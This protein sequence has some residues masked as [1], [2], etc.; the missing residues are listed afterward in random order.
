MRGLRFGA[1]TS[2]SIDASVAERRGE[3]TADTPAKILFTSGST[4]L[5][6]GVLNTHGNLAAAL[7]MA[8]AVGE[9]LDESRI[10]V[11]LDWLPWHHTWGGNANL[12]GDVR[13]A[14]SLYIDDGRPLPGR[15]GETLK[16][17]GELSPS[18]FG[19]VPAAY[20]LLL[21][22]LERDTDFRERFFKNLRGLSYGSALLPQ[23]SFDRLQRLAVGQLG[24]RLPFG[25]GWGM[26]E[27]TSVGMMV[28]WNVERAGLLGLP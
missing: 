17:L 13:V 6:K 19:T 8:R 24:E 16:N 27:T 14:G 23:E 18:H 9:P 11:S 10:G 7:E 22:A 20:P 26:T 15:F 25:S 21:E 5:P 28:Y 1:L 4:G 3:I 2:S 12:N